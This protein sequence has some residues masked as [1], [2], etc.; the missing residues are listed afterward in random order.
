M[1]P[2]VSDQ[3]S[4]T[5]DSDGNKHW[6]VT[7]GCSYVLFLR[8]LCPS[9]SL[10]H[11]HTH[12]RHIFLFSP[13]INSRWTMCLMS[14]WWCPWSCDLTA[15]KGNTGDRS[16]WTA[17][18]SA[19]V[20]VCVCGYAAWWIFPPDHTCSYICTLHIRILSARVC[21][22]ETNKNSISLDYV[23]VETEGWSWKE[24]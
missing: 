14:L 7:Q 15:Q 11:T 8:C 6:D 23:T 2:S 18:H 21:A 22:C 19:G 9:L 17:G 3:R 4:S 13:I 10:T 12:A 20:C 16:G 1:K 24:R 5:R